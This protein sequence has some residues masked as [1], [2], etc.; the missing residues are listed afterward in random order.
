MMTVT[1]FDRGNVSGEAT[2]TDEGYIRAN[3]IVTRTGVFFYQNP[4]GS[5]RRELRHPDDVWE[6]ESLAS[7]H[8][9]PV[10]NGH[11]QEKLVNSENYKNLA[12]GF[13]GEKITQD[14][15]FVRANLVITD[16]EGVEYVT[17]NN[18]KNLSL[19]YTVDLEDESGEYNGEQYDA[20]QRNIRYNHL[21]IVNKARAGDEARIALD[22]ADAFEISQEEGEQMTKRK[23]KL[24]NEEIMVEPATAEYVDRLMDDLKNLEEEKARVQREIEMIR[25]KLERAEGERDSM[26]DKMS[27][28]TEKVSLDSADFKKAVA[29]RINLYKVAEKFLD[30]ETVKLD[31]MSD[32]DIKKSV[33]EKCR[34]SISL[35]G[36]SDYYVE[37][38]FDTIVDDAKHNVNVKNVSYLQENLDGG[39]NLVSAQEKM[40]ISL[41]NMNKKAV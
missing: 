17:R 15:D 35:D 22:E 16:K 7:M 36:K 34:K 32:L 20:R 37:A 14:G 1:R 31:S 10:T 30:I 4:D 28:M 13:T 3:A 39:I 40:K 18:R 27:T 29:D 41:K 2:I 6:E 19:G 25:M 11:P 8:L 38:M 9:I 5:V 21:A 26:K 24:D 33:I 12:I 23:I